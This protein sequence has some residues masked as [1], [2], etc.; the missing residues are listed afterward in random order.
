VG[1]VIVPVLADGFALLQAATA[2]PDMRAAT[3]TLI[4]P[5]DRA[6]PSGG[7]AFTS[8]LFALPK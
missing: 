1:F 8:N 3:M 4:C 7:P 2:I 6:L 5:E